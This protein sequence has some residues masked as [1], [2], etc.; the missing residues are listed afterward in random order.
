MAYKFGELELT[1][2]VFINYI[3][4]IYKLKIDFNRSELKSFTNLNDFETWLLNP[5]DFNY[6]IFDTKWLIDISNYSIIFDRLRNI[7]PIGAA[8]EIELNKEF[9]S[10]LAK[11]KY[12]YFSVQI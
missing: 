11:I 5:I 10:T 9:N 4:I 1:D 8:I 7:E 3:F 2:L 12:K 6:K